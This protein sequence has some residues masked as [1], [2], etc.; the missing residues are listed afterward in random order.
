MNTSSYSR[1]KYERIKQHTIEGFS[2]ELIV[3]SLGNIWVSIASIIGCYKR[4]E[5]IDFWENRADYMEKR[6]LNDGS[7]EDDHL[8][9]EHLYRDAQYYLKK[10]KKNVIEIL[11]YEVDLPKPELMKRFLEILSEMAREYLL[12]ALKEFREEI[13]KARIEKAEED[14]LDARLQQANKANVELKKEYRK[15]DLITHG[16]INEPST[17]V[18]M[19]TPVDENKDQANIEVSNQNS[20]RKM[21]TWSNQLAQTKVISS[22]RNRKTPAIK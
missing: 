4:W 12:I 9:T 1:M 17:Q 13:T 18:T 16:Q 14:A 22:S 10:D 11:R 15:L 20:D 8:Q 21:V 19:A 3:K 7:I 6:L 2:E 5:P